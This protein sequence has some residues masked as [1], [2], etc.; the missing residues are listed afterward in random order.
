MKVKLASTSIGPQLIVKNPICSH[1]TADYLLLLLPKL[2]AKA[3][4]K[5]LYKLRNFMDQRTRYSYC[6]LIRSRTE[7]DAFELRRRLFLNLADPLSE[8]SWTARLANT[9]AFVFNATCNRTDEPGS[10]NS[11][12]DWKKASS[13]TKEMEILQTIL[14]MHYEMRPVPE[15]MNSYKW[16]EDIKDF[17][18]RYDLIGDALQKRQINELHGLKKSHYIGFFHYEC[19]LMS[20]NENLGLCL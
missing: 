15:L 12:E 2:R 8:S 5:R 18:R 4:Y 14:R 20:L 3:M 11:Y 13:S 6:H 19:T 16:V 9:Y 7:Q 1:I 17:Y 10:V